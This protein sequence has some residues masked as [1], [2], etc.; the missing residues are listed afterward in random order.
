[1]S[2][3][4]RDRALADLRARGVV[5]DDDVARAEVRRN[6]YRRFGVDAPV[7]ELLA[8][9]GAVPPDVVEEASRGDDVPSRVAGLEIV[10]PVGGTPDRPVYL[11]RRPLDGE[12][13]LVHACM[14]T[15][16]EAPTEV[17]QFVRC[18]E[19]GRRL[20]GTG[21]I[22]VREAAGADGAY[23][24]VS[25]VPEGLRLDEHLRTKG[26]LAP[27]AAVALLRRVGEA[28]WQ[29]EALGRAA[30]FPD[31]SLVVLDASGAPSLPAIEVL[32]AGRAGGFDAREFARSAAHFLARL[33]GPERVTDPAVRDLL[34][35]L[36]SGRFEVLRS[37]RPTR[38]LVAEPAPTADA[39]PIGIET[40]VRLTAPS[41][42]V[43][44]DAPAPA[45]TDRGLRVGVGIAAAVVAVGGLAWALRG[46]RPP[47]EPA[48]T[49]AA[50]AAERASRDRGGDRPTARG[51]ETSA[52]GPVVR[53]E[54][55]VAL[56]DALGYL[57]TRRGED[58]RGVVDRLRAVEA[59]YGGTD[60][61][62]RARTE[63]ERF[64]REVEADAERRVQSI[65]G[66]V[67]RFL[68]VDE[69]GAAHAAI[70]GFPK[71]LSFT[72]AVVRLDAL[73][74]A[75]KQKAQSIYDALRPT[76]DAAADPSK[77]DAA[78]A[79][80]D[81]IRSLGDAELLARA[82][83]R[84]RDATG[85]ADAR[86][87]ARAAL[88]PEL[89]RAVG[90]ALAAV[91]AGDIERARR[92]IEAAGRGPLGAAFPD[93]LGAARES[94]DRVARVYAA[95][96][97]A[98]KA[99]A[100]RAATV[101]L[102]EYGGKPFPVTPTDAS[103]ERFAWTRGGA[104]G[105]ARV[106][107]L[108]PETVV[109]LATAS[110]REGDAG[111]A[112]G[113]A[114]LY[115]ATGR[116]A[117]ADAAAARA[118]ALGASTATFS[119]E[120]AAVRP[121]LEA[122][123]TKECAAADAVLERDR[124]GGKQGYGRA[125]VLAPFLALPHRRLAEALSA[126]KRADDALAEWRRAVALGDRS[127]DALFGLARATGAAGRPDDET[128]DAWREFVAAASAGDPRLEAA[129]TEQERL[130]RKVVR[131]GTLERVK[132]A[133]ALLDAGKAAEAVAAVEQALREDPGSLEGLRLL[134]RAAEKADD[135]V[136]AY[137]AWRRAHDVATAAK[138]AADAKEQ[139]ERLLRLHGERAAEVTVRKSAEASLARSE[140][141]TAAETY[142]RA[143]AM[144]P[145][146]VEARM[147]LGAALLGLA[148]KTGSKPLFEEGY[149]AYDVAVQIDPE[150]ARTWWGRA[151]L[152]R[153][154]GDYD[155]AVAD[156]SA[157]IERRKDLLAA[158]N[159]RALSQYQALRF[160]AA[161]ADMNVVCTLAPLLATPRITRAGVLLALGRVADAEADLAAALERSP[162]EPE[163]AQIEELRRQA[164]ARRKGGGR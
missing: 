8:S 135:P 163:K 7:L 39:T 121:R 42:P 21:W 148:L 30:T 91:G 16:A 94:V 157:A 19:E 12:T 82:E 18:A 32:L 59:R 70:D 137:V 79:A 3:T 51:T 155:G 141:A 128:L 54:G 93:R 120:A 15:R 67:E 90:E 10:R 20:T 117:E 129:R 142:K 28:L 113:V 133:K 131:G 72:R 164:V 108:D 69:L 132:A 89:A 63:R 107:A 99:R 97:G 77:Q 47:A 35:E 139:A 24:A 115:A 48:G 84:L 101:R 5:T 50:D 78:R 36:G 147:G 103:G 27:T 66:D 127:A 43:R 57:T 74:D 106:G 61:A 60:A 41:A 58:P 100:G 122:L 130:A 144:S 98:W 118:A 92:S 145:L 87:A 37:E 56:E 136:R 6:E 88:E 25:P 65:A 124:E 4:A 110:G 73:R 150:D 11:A 13:F 138:D 86:N 149:A 75:V 68:A 162:S 102:R 160:D 80:I 111:I 104:P 17:D 96:A 46:G 119:A 126:D 34:T 161:L 76:I 143:I 29:M 31:P 114:T 85:R 153:W 105:G 44:R 62:D 159:T 52:P 22:P 45:R 2:A 23:A 152:R 26:H 109:T 134:A 1:M 156:A 158:W 123:A 64:E 40:P 14:R 71:V 9:A 125:A 33:V 151:E 95:A 53:D 116:F 83:A 81:R 38:A 146:D 112:L 49:A 55:M 140:H 154:K